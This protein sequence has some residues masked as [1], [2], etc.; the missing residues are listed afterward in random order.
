MM[1]ANVPA[2]FLGEVVTKVVPLQY[3]DA[4]HRPQLARDRVRGLGGRSRIWRGV[5]T[6]GEQLMDFHL[7]RGLRLP[8]EPN[9]SWAINEIDA[10]G[11]TIGRDQ[12]PWEWTFYFTA[13]SCFL[14]DS[15]EIDPPFDS[16]FKV[17]NQDGTVTEQES[18]DKEEPTIAQS[19]LIR[20]RLRSG[21]RG[22]KGDEDYFRETQF[23]M[24]GT[25]RAI[26]HF[27]LNIKPLA[28][29]AKQERCS[30]W[31]CVSYTS[32]VDFR[33]ET[34]EDCIV[35]SFF[36]KPETFARYAEKV[37]HGLIDE[38]IFRVGGVDGFY[39]EWSPSISTRN[40]KV[41]TAEG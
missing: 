27:E 30:A 1:L 40:V 13:T 24:F 16:K 3:T 22:D 23:S 18:S 14:C 33:Y 38:V 4:R 10:Q 41:L 32:E 35:F 29:P 20:A 12:M 25:D 2:V 17:T 36:V 8:K 5:S 31:G 34:R 37:A 28:D 6:A 19:Q 11:Q 7:E 26:K 9:K 21:A 39:S 15:I